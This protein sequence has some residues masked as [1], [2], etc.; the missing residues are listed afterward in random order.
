MSV[1]IFFFFFFFPPPFLVSTSFF[2][3]NGGAR[4]GLRVGYCAVVTI[5]GGSG[6]TDEGCKADYLNVFD[7]GDDLELLELYLGLV[8]S[9]GVGRCAASS[10]C[11]EG[12]VL[13]PGFFCIRRNL[14]NSAAV[15]MQ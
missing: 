13:E 6:V 12:A 10:A 8:P 4:S 2:K 14:H 1:G 11:S 3:N 15:A 5:K 9:R 7:A